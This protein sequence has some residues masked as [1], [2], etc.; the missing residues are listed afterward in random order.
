MDGSGVG[1][2][3]GAGVLEWL[4]CVFPAVESESEDAIISSP[5]TKTWALGT[6]DLL[7]LSPFFFHS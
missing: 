1:G 3:G 2:G 5:A 4:V 6:Y 7:W